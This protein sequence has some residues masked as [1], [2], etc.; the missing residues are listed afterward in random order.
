MWK[1]KRI[2]SRTR[3]QISGAKLRPF[4]IPKLNEITKNRG[5]NNF[6]I[7]VYKTIADPISYRTLRKKITK[8][9]RKYSNFENNGESSL[10][11]KFYLFRNLNF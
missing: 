3:S 6:T 5:K 9:L 7:T 11:S 10:F 4:M 8:I 1:R 2:K